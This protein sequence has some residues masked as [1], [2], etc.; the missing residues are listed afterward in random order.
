[1]QIMHRETVRAP[2]RVFISLSPARWCNDAWQRIMGS[3]WLDSS[4]LLVMT[5]VRWQLLLHLQGHLHIPLLSSFYLY[6]ALLA[7][8][9]I[10]ILPWS[11]WSSY[12]LNSSLIYPFFP[13]KTTKIT[14]HRCIN[15]YTH[16]HKHARTPERH[17][18]PC[19][20]LALCPWGL[21][22]HLRLCFHLLFSVFTVGPE[23]TLFICVR[24]SLQRE[25]VSP[26]TRIRLNFDFPSVPLWQC[27]PHPDSNF[28]P[29]SSPA[30]RLPLWLQRCLP[31]LGL[32]GRGI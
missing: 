27:L 4:P 5:D 26:F 2:K 22:N 10:F 21:A 16:A 12:C 24:V 9:C 29:A 32:S 3:V 13:L 31:P 19:T 30:P 11:L 17:K 6:L 28:S 14:K 7:L 25:C 23:G 15:T 1:M 18:S 8:F 20:R